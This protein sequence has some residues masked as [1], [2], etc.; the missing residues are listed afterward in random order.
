MWGSKQVIPHFY[1]EIIVSIVSIASMALILS[2]PYGWF[3]H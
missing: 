1:K 2:A 3:R